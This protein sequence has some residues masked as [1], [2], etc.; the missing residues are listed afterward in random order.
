MATTVVILVENNWH[1]IWR[2]YELTFK[3]DEISSW[4]LADAV[5]GVACCCELAIAI[6]R[7]I[8]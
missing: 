3:A 1:K 5:V 6:Q 4:R 2:N 8:S 7:A